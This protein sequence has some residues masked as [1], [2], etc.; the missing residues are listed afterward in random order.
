LPSVI[1]C[2]IEEFVDRASVI[3][4][5]VGENWLKAG[6]LPTLRKRDH[7]LVSC[8]SRAVEF[9][10]LLKNEETDRHEEFYATVRCRSEG[11][12]TQVILNRGFPINFDRKTEW[13][14]PEDIALA[15]AIIF[16]AVPQAVTLPRG[17]GEAT[18]VR[19]DPQCQC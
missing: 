3:I 2:E 6:Q 5:C 8:S 15:R 11:G 14:R 16:A 19:L 18:G 12:I 10:S 17:T 7:T 13:E 9:E 4:G 1:R